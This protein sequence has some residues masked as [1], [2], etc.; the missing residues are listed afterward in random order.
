[1]RLP[2]DS[3]G[4]TSGEA[5]VSDVDRSGARRLDGQCKGILARVAERYAD[6][7]EVYRKLG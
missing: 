4:M 7:L 5:A 1:M 3:C 2:L 6:E